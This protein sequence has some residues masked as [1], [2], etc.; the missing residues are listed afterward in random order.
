MGFTRILLG[1]LFAHFVAFC[2][3]F[4]AARETGGLFGAFCPARI[5][6]GYLNTAFTV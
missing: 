2:R 6:L 5:C 1:A 4:S 3:G